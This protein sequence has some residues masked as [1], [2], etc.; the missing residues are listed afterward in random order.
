[1]DGVKARMLE[2]KKMRV[3]L[4]HRVMNFAKNFKHLLDGVLWA[5][6]LASVAALFLAHEDPFARDA[7]CS[8]I[9]FC[10]VIANAKAWNKILYDLAV[11]ALVSLLFCLLVVRLPDYQKR[12][13]IKRNLAKQYENFREDCIEIMLIVSDG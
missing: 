10:P 11:G 6:F 5:I 2:I 3:V 4:L 1:M 13:R 8:Q 12:L 7:L 9:R